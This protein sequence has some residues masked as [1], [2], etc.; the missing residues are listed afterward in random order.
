MRIT[1]RVVRH[2]LDRGSASLPGRLE[3]HVARCLGCQAARI[4]VRRLERG[5][6]SLQERVE[7]AP[8]GLLDSVVAAAGV[9]AL[10]LAVDEEPRRSLG[11]A[12]SVV[13]TT[14]AGAA[15]AVAGGV[16]VLVWRRSHGT[17]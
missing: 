8:V 7:P 15:G 2:R 4:R 11:R 14:V 6:L 9:A 13:A 10:R 12:S 16:A 3:S 1:C 5:M 17:A